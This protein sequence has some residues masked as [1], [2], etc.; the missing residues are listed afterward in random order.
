M[1]K[2]NEK[3]INIGLLS[4]MFEDNNLGCVALSICNVMLLDRA[5]KELGVNIKYII[6]V[7]EKQKQLE[8]NFTNTLYEYRV[9]SS[10]KQSIKHPIKLLTTKI[11]DDCDIVFN[12][13]A[14]DGFTDIYGFGRVLSESYMT[15]IGHFKGARIILAPQTIGPFRT[16]VTRAIAKK[17]L[18][19]CDMVFSRDKMS[20]S[21]CMELGYADITKEII[22]VAFILP[23][24]K[25]TRENAEINIGLNV[26]GLL[27]HGGYDFNNYFGLSFNYKDF[28]ELLINQLLQAGY[29]VHLIAHV[30]T[31]DGSIE[32]DFLVCSELADKYKGTV[33]MPKMAS[34]MAVKSYLSGMDVF[35]G[36]RMHST[37]GAFSAGVPVIP[38][39]YSRKFNGLFNTLD[40]PYYIDAKGNYTIQSA[41]DETMHFINKREVM[42]KQLNIGKDIYTNRIN[43]YVESIKEYL[44]NYMA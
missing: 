4:H 29:V 43:K 21:F 36:G 31:S 13:C 3:F 33:L 42:R 34:P 5:A 32:D 18:A 40:Y 11:F 27:Y 12:L 9:Y 15:I 25:Y 44:A 35:I 14:G 17:A 39:A 41:V 6:Y 2:H 30:I 16:P 20:T 28:I 7:N 23:F 19:C 1:N 8:L 10:C 24:E 22:D 26:S 38:I 37:I